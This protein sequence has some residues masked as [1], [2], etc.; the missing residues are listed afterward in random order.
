MLDEGGEQVLLTHHHKARLWFQFGGH[1]EAG[2]AS[3]WHGAA[4]EAREESGIDALTVLPEIVH[5]DRHELAASSAA[6]GSTSTCA[7]RRSPRPARGH[8]VSDE[9][10]DVR[11]WPADRLPEEPRQTSCRSSSGARR[12][13]LTRR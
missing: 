5:L 7:S 3:M 4:R 11:W 1:F 10:L 9:S 6:A 2:D 13:A 8:R 12:A